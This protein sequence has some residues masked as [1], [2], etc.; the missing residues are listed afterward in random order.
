MIRTL[1]IA[2]FAT[3]H[4]AAADP[5]TDRVTRSGIDAFRNAYQAWDA[6]GFTTAAAHF[7][8]AAERAPGAHQNHYWRGVAL[9]HHMLHLRNQRPPRENAAARSMD[10]AIESLETAVKLNPRDAESH[11]LLGTLYGMRIHGGMLRAIRFGPRVQE[12]QREAL[13]H[14]AHNPRVRYLLGAARFHTAKNRAGYLEA[15][16]TLQAAEKLFAAEAAQRHRDPT[17]PRWGAGSC[18]TFIGRAYLELGERKHAA[19]Y[20]RRALAA[21][22]NDHIARQE[23]DRLNHAD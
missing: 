18:L 8:K 7:Q 16:K 6:A 2:L 5:A 22:P 1:A 23:L 11:A 10:L 9:F 3:L 19:E 20:F 17:A 4:P 21:H 15:L 14:G 12:H 13:A